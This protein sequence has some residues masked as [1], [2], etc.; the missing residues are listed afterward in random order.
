RD[1]GEQRNLAS[2]QPEKVRELEALW[3]HQ[4]EQTTALAFTDPPPPEAPKKGKGA[5]GR[6]SGEL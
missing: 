3:K 2:T 6:K 4:M 1:R 5:K